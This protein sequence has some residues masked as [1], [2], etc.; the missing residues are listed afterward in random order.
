MDSH[1]TFISDIFLCICTGSAFTMNLEWSRQMIRRSWLDLKSQ[2]TQKVTHL[3]HWLL[4]LHHQWW[5]TSKRYEATVSWWNFSHAPMQFSKVEETIYSTYGRGFV[6][7]AFVKVWVWWEELY[8]ILVWIV[9]IHAPQV[10]CKNCW[11]LTWLK[12]A[13]TTKSKYIMCAAQMAF[14]PSESFW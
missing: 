13:N 3:R 5:E 12:A 11:W 8:E 10:G 4:H 6:L 9:A 2:L 7:P 1:A 14:A